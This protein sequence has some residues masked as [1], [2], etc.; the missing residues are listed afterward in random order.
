VGGG[1]VQAESSATHS[2]WKP[3]GFTSTLE[4]LKKPPGFWFQP[5]NLMK[6]DIQVSSLCFR[7]GQLVG[8][9]PLGLQLRHIKKG[10]LTM[11]NSARNA[12][13]GG[14]AR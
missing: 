7:M 10:L 3:R 8:R 12:N 6:C 9:L 13:G 11:S 14:G 4:R 1:A 5:L 2:A